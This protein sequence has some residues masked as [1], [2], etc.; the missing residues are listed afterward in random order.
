VSCLAANSATVPFV[1]GGLSDGLLGDSWVILIGAGLFYLPGLLLLALATVPFL[2][3]AKINHC[4][5]S[6]A[7]LALCPIGIRLVRPIMSVLGAKQFH[8]VLQ[9]SVLETFYIY[10]YLY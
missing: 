8:P 3:G 9:S 6:G 2:L 1:G 10:Y 5:L 4:V 7:L